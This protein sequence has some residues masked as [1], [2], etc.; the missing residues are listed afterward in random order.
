[1]PEPIRIKILV[2]KGIYEGVPVKD[3]KGNYF[4]AWPDDV[5]CQDHYVVEMVEAA[6]LLARIEKLEKA[7][8]EIAGYRLEMVELER[9]INDSDVEYLEKVAEETLKP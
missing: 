4:K 7:L 2:H 3:F 6:P 8:R 1:M 9:G 5:S